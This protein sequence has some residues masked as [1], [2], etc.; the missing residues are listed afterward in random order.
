MPIPANAQAIYTFLTG[1]GFSPNAAAGIV[2][3]IEQESGGSPT[4]GSN[5][6]GRGLIQIL[7]DPGGSL[8]QELQRTMT[9][10]KANGSVSD[11]NAHASSPSEA[12]LYFST[13]YERP[14]PAAANNANREASANAVAA[15]AKSGNW[16]TG[17][18]GTPATTTGFDP[19]GLGG[20]VNAFTGFANN[21][22]DMFKIF[23]DLVSPAFWLRIGMFL[24]GLLLLAFGVYA[25]VK[26]DSDTGFMPKMPTVTPVPI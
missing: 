10:I 14:N 18:G 2:G 23:H 24:A 11:I 3:N 5:P 15:A 26:A 20:L 16:S 4:A 9:Y 7:G 13:K 19:F 17:S 6:P 12:A 22:G 21:F 8:A 1:A 25:F